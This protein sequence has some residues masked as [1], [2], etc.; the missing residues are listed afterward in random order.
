MEIPINYLAVIASAISA[1]A[2]GF[3]WFGPLFGKQWIAAM[4]WT[5]AEVAA[6]REK[7][8]K[9]GWK[10]YGIQAIGALVMAYVL[11]HALIFGMAYTQTYGV[12]GG[13][14]GAFWYWLGF[15][16]PVMLGIVL[17]DGKPWALFFIQGGYYLITMLVMGVILALWV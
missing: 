4:G 6:G 3:V 10:T 9:E 7:M 11:A 12:V 15:V 13:L 17:W 8:Q 16:A 1:M 2:L 14:T 5:E